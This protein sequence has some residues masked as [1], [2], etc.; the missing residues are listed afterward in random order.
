MGHPCDAPLKEE[1]KVSVFQGDFLGFQ[2]GN[3]HSYRLNITRVSTNDRYSDMLLPSF[4]DAVVQ[5]PGGDG[6]YY[7]DSYYTQKPFTID[8]AFDDLR[9]EDIR[10]LRQMFSKK[11]LQPLV[12]DELPYK[13]YMVKCAAPPQLR[14]ICFDHNEFRIYKGEG[15]ASLVAYYPF[16][17][18]VVS[19]ELEYLS[20]GSVVNNPGDLPA[21]ME[22]VYNLSN[23]GSEVSLEL[24][25]E[26][27]GSDIGQLN[28]TDI[29]AEA[30]DTYMV[31]NTRTQLIEGYDAAMNKTG[32]LYNRYI[33]SGDFFFPPVGRT[34]L[35]SSLPFESAKYTPMYY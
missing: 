25:E 21:Y 3:D 20:E 18:A 17:F 35:L 22:I 31:I 2:L 1:F 27:N 5:V 9:D 16:A 19:P 28:L 4:T 6:T 15:T 7:W 30:G 14:Y 11:E 33:D 13:K 34:Y 23:I 12:F 32:T 24:R 8:F 26:Q 29:V 10:S